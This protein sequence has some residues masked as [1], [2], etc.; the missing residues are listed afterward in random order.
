M[1]LKT[2]LA[3]IILVW[4]ALTDL[5]ASVITPT[6]VTGLRSF[7]RGGNVLLLGF[8]A[9]KLGTEDRTVAHFDI[10]KF[11]F[12]HSN[13]TIPLQNIDPGG[14]DGI[15]EVYSFF[16][17]G[18]V[19][20]DE[21]SVGTFLTSFGGLTDEFQTVSVDIFDLLKTART[22][23]NQYL[24]FSLRAGNSDRYWLVDEVGWPQISIISTSPSVPEPGT[25]FLLGVG[26][27]TVALWR[28][29]R[30]T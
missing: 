6:D 24:S 22:G 19:S 25:V 15:L 13:L 11:P 4:A 10:S 28:K 5:H 29:R 17:D 30:A 8:S 12:L 14:P 27:F 9:V 2:I 23:H 7:D 21:W 26:V 16:G 18:E 20:T 3:A 1:S